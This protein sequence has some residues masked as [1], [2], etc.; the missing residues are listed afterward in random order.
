MPVPGQPIFHLITGGQGLLFIAL[1][2]NSVNN[3]LGS[4][5]KSSPSQQV[6]A[7]SI[8]S[9]PGAPSTHCPG[10]HNKLE[11]QG[12]VII[13]FCIM[14]T[15][16][17]LEKTHGHDVLLLLLPWPSVCVHACSVTQLCPTLCGPMDCSPPGSSVHG[18]SPGKNTGVG[19][20]ALLQG[21]FPTQ[22]LNPGLHTTNR[23][24]TI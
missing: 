24:F 5:L 19:R 2:F 4:T 22:G 1:S 14:H 12:A 21:L 15:S 23:F 3:S 13:E 9:A 17:S 11:S 20:H 18:N 10:D 8:H 6:A 7:K 16:R